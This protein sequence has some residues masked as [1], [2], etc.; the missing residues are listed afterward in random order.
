MG[1]CEEVG[2]YW[3]CFFLGGVLGVVR[4]EGSLVGEELCLGRYFF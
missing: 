4:G 2:G 3:F 1:R